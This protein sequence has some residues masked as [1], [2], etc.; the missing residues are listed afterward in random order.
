ML[1]YTQYLKNLH[2][3]RESA[4]TILLQVQLDFPYLHFQG[5]SLYHT[6][7]RTFHW[8]RRR[9]KKSLIKLKKQNEPHL[10]TD[11]NTCI[12]TRLAEK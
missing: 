5:Q 7:M 10:Q 4:Q 8:L 11:R 2:K 6:Y 1:T 3:N 9:T 12:N